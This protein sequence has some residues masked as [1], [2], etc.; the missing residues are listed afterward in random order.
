[1]TT[2]RKILFCLYCLLIFSTNSYSAENCYSIKVEK[3][4]WN[5]VNSVP[6]YAIKGD[7]LQFYSSSPLIIWETAGTA[8]KLS[9][10]KEK[11]F[12]NSSWQFVMDHSDQPYRHFKLVFK[13]SLAG[14]KVDAFATIKTGA[15][16]RLLDEERIFSNTVTV[17][18]PDIEATA[19]SIVVHVHFSKQPILKEYY[20]GR[21]GPITNIKDFDEGF[22]KVGRLFFYSPDAG[23][24]E[25]CVNIKVSESVP[26]EML[27]G[28]PLE[29]AKI[30]AKEEIN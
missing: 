4:G 20:V 8:V 12:G 29:E 27:K 15:T 19:V 7:L 16:V 11:K 14:K 25:M 13:E 6:D 22:Q 26:M 18:W 1:M 2:M 9:S 24:R 30:V 10:N 3:P 17:T 5:F 21:Q 28:R 23:S